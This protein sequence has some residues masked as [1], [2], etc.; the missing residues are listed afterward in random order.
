MSS[1]SEDDS[2]TDKEDEGAVSQ[3]STPVKMT[4]AGENAKITE[5]VVQ[6]IKDGYGINL[7]ESPSEDDLSIYTRF[8]QLGQSQHKQDKTHQQLCSK[9]LD[10]VINLTHISAFSQDNIYEVQ[11]PKVDRKSIEIFHAHIQAGKGIM[12]PL[13]KEDFLM[14]REYIRNRYM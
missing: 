14:Y 2:G 9:H 10:G 12:Q 11:P 4:D 1:S 3:R 7:S 13:G 6:C 8:V 5:N